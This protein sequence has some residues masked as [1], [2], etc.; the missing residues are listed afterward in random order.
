MLTACT[1]IACNYLPYARVLVDSFFAHHP[2][3]TFIALLLDDE[4]QQ[5]VPDDD[6]VDWRRL[7]DIGLESAEIRRLAGIYDVTELATAVK[8]VLLTRLLDEGHREIIYLDPD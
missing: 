3:G 8:P 2:G 1:I 6:R 7:S 5:F 4:E